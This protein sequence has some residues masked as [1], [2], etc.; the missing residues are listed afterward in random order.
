[1]NPRDDFARDRHG[2]IIQDRYGRPVRRRTSGANSTGTRHNR[3]APSRD[4]ATRNAPQPPQ[5]PRRAPRQEAPS[6]TRFFPAQP[7]GIA[8]PPRPPA[9]RRRR[10]APEDEG[11]GGP[12]S[13]QYSYAGQPVEFQSRLSQSKPST[14]APLPRAKKRRRRRP[15]FLRMVVFALVALLVISTGTALW[16]DAKLQRAEAIQDYEGR[17]E[18]TAG[19]NW[20]LVGSD[21]RAG[22]TEE[23]AHRLMAGE[24]TEGVGR[25]DTIMIVHIPRLGGKATIL[26]LPRDSWVNIPGYGEDKLNAAFS[27][28]GPAL[29]QQTVEQST[30]LRIDRYAEIG[31]GGFANVVD[32]VGGIEMCLDEPLQDPMAGIDLAAGCQKLDGPTALGYVRSRYTSAG[33]DIDRVDRQ[34]AFLAALSDKIASIGTLANPFRFFLLMG[35]VADS[36]TVNEKD[37]VWNLA[38]LGLGIAG[39][40]TQ[41]TVPV[42]GYID[43]WAGNAVLWDEAA[44]EA[45]FSELR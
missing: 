43:T 31:F 30:G 3:A 2:R 5:P 1:M 22:M 15:R 38:G 4:D 28:G 34:K 12:Q 16:A 17:I 40:A 35:A 37:H 27:L 18:D 41:E 21:S 19:T 36:L 45:I 8:E 6:H 13:V 9:R 10:P 20:L 32:A 23:D 42:G 39:G 29:L 33:G 24:I 7:T 14:D 11:D 44:A 26:S 25:T